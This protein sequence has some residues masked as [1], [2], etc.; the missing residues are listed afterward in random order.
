MKHML[1]RD[2]LRKITRAKGRFF[3]LMGIIA[4]SS[5][6]FS[7]LKVTS[8]NMKRS[9]EQ[10]YRE[11][12]LMDLHLISNV[13]FCEE[14]LTLL[15]DL[16]GVLAVNSGYSEAAFL[17]HTPGG[18]AADTIV[19]LYSFDL[20]AVAEGAAINLPILREGN[21]PSAANECLIEVNTPKQYGIGDTLSVMIADEAA[22]LLKE[23]Q[24][25]VVGIA[26][27]SMHVNFE[28]GTAA[29]G[30]GSIDSF[31]L[32]PEAAFRQDVYTDIY[33]TL[34][35]TQDMDCYSDAY[36]D[37]VEA[38]ADT[39]EANVTAYAKPRVEQLKQEAARSLSEARAELDNGWAAL[40][41]NQQRFAQEIA[42]AETELADAAA[43]LADGQ[44]Q[45]E[46]G[47]AQYQNGCLAYE[48]G[49]RTLTA[50]EDTLVQ[51]EQQTAQS[52]RDLEQEINAL[53][54]TRNIVNGYRDSALGLPFP[55]EI[56]SLIDQAVNYD[57]DVFSLSQTMT[58]YFQAA[59]GSAEKERMELTISYYISNC[60]APLKDGLA[61]CER[62][63]AKLASARAQ[64][65]TAKAALADTKTML[66]NT[67]AELDAAKAELEQAQKDYD[68]GSAMLSQQKADGRQQLSEAE[69]KLKDG[70]TAYTQAQ[71]DADALEESAAWYVMD[72]TANPG[73]SNYAMDADRVDAIAAVFP[74]F[75]LLVAALVCLT[76]MTRMVEEQ[77]TEI[78]TYQ[79]LGYSSTAIALQFLLYALLASVL[80]VAA[81]TLICFQLFP[82][83]IFLCYQL[84]YRF[85]P[86]A[87]PYHWQYALGCLGAALLCTGC[88]AMAVCYHALR[89]MPS[90]L[91]RPKPPKQGK[92]VLLEH[93]KWLWNKLSFHTKV[94]IRNFLRYRSRMLMTVIGISGCTALLLT[95]FGL[96]Y[97]VS[98]IVDLQYKEVFAYDAM[99]SFHSESE[100]TAVLDA[101]LAEDP[102]VLQYQ[103]AMCK[104]STIYAN[105]ASYEIILEVPAQP[106]SFSDYVR[107]RDRKTH[108]ACPLTDAGVVINEKLAKLLSVSVGDSITLSDAENAVTVTGIC[109]NY[110]GNYVFFTPTLYASLFGTEENNVIYAVL[111]DNTDEDA[112]AQR[113][114]EQDAVLSVTFA[115]TSGNSFRELVDT[116]KYIVLLVIGCSG[117]LAFVVLYHLSNINITERMRE[118]A[119]IKVLGFYPNE[120]AA[121]IYRENL[122]SSL[123]GTLCGSVLGIFLCR[124]VV[125]TAEVDMVM[126][127]PDIPLYCFLCAALLTMLFTLLVN[128]LLRPKLNAIDMAASMKAIE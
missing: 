14:N 103:Y 88:T 35:D 112:L 62:A 60:L 73:W 46:N 97:A 115:S 26:D 108:A 99:L 85:P 82:K 6:F 110:A 39:I 10:Y 31:L 80:G 74:V 70:E 128:G 83:V 113:L 3:A 100:Q 114:M 19:K 106:E 75:F 22:S 36:L 17:P 12:N 37:T 15:R 121:Y 71:A 2:S 125:Q 20:D 38:F 7:G 8:P 27:W 86:I 119:T 94:T 101:A 68:D 56:Q 49:L 77:R 21:Y 44:T 102:A 55:N 105:D 9:A 90:Q 16:E 79:A 69:Q 78:G 24:F 127:C 23:T 50:Q 93:W 63:E 57:S 5:G 117:L 81:G 40:S 13:G 61:E 33:L 42:A 116:L 65:E 54:R 47:S 59:A 45:W 118:L 66:D 32:V 120:I 4:L 41:E 29:I 64:L 87:C 43:L 95:G 91:M 111:Q 107:L 11:T 84:L 96:H 123:L 1:L 98:A 51:Q 89:E 30:N 58:A 53:N 122:L 76:T 48:E 52:K 124:F 67:K 126:F 92:H 104:A 72:R 25:T 34:T 109:E 28:R 18:T